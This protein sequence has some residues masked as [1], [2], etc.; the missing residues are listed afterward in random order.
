[1]AVLLR[2]IL[3]GL[4]PNPSELFPFLLIAW[5]IVLKVGDCSGVSVRRILIVFL[6]FLRLSLFV[7]FFVL[8]YGLPDCVRCDIGHHFM[9]Y[10]PFDLGYLE[11]VMRLTVVFL[12]S[13]CWDRALITEREEWAKEARAQFEGKID[14]RSCQNSNNNQNIVVCACL[15]I[16][17][18]FCTRSSVQHCEKKSKTPS[19]T[20]REEIRTHKS[21]RWLFSSLVRIRR[22]LTCCKKSP[23]NNKVFVSTPETSN[24]RQREK[25]DIKKREK[26]IRCSRRIKMFSVGLSLVSFV[27]F[28]Y[29]LMYL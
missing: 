11:L 15:A 21:C 4:E 1:M 27:R 7:G 28:F 24:K 6:I 29:V 18:V 20:A 23:T 9:C 22:H 17:C 19:P 3:I 5:P 2:H 26:T 13:F 25:K 16:V 10:R 8:F 14:I 12:C